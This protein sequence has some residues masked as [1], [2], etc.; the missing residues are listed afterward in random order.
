MYRKSDSLR[1]VPGTEI[2]LKVNC[3]SKANKLIEKE[4]RSVVTTDGGW[5]QREL[6]EGGQ[7]V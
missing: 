5:G 2:E 3:T 6:D 4:I 1:C 7:K